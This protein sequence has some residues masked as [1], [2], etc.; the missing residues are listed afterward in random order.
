MSLWKTLRFVV[1]VATVCGVATLAE[2]QQ[3]APEPAPE[4]P[5]AAEARESPSPKPGRP[6]PAAKAAPRERPAGE[7]PPAP[8]APPG[9]R[10]NVRVDIKIRAQRGSGAP[11]EKTLALVAIGDNSRTSVRTASTVPFPTGVSLKADVRAT[12][13][14]RRILVAL[15]LDYTFATQA[16]EGEGRAAGTQTSSV[17]NEIRAVLDDGKPLVVSD[18]VDAGGDYRVTVEAKATILR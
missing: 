8:A 17:Q 15:S 6:A 5:V 12:V 14:G 10:V 16:V 18:Q 3:P 1:V 11:V 4:G 13:E 2:S 9:E 7:A